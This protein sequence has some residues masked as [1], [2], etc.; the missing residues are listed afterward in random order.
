MGLKGL[1]EANPMA[2]FPV[3]P[4]VPRKRFWLIAI[5]EHAQ[6]LFLFRGNPVLERRPLSVRC[7]GR[8]L[9]LRRAEVLEPRLQLE[10]R[11]VPGAGPGPSTWPS[12]IK[13]NQHPKL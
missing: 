5:P 3:S 9:R 6:N 8:A 11:L 13:N 12:Q 7:R 4:T 10:V 1:D 2:V